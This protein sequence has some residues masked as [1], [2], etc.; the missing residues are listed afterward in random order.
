MRTAMFSGKIGILLLAASL[1]AENLIWNSGFELGCGNWEGNTI[2]EGVTQPR[3]RC[4]SMKVTSGNV[5]RGKY[6]LHIPPQ[7]GRIDTLISS[8]SFTVKEN[9]D[10]NFSFDA[11][12]DRPGTAVSV[13]VTSGQRKLVRDEAGNIL[14]PH[15]GPV[16]AAHWSR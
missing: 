1:S 14:P 5:A 8:H 6:A 10:Y 2:M 11:M 4:T 13:T 16:S 9:S 3:E 15:P 7:P 12:T